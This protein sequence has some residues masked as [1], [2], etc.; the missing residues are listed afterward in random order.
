MQRICQCHR[1]ENMLFLFL[2]TDARLRQNQQEGV[3]QVWQTNQRG[4]VSSCSPT[5]AAEKK[6]DLFGLWLDFQEDWDKVQC[7]VERRS[8]STNLS[9]SEWCAVQAKEL[10]GKMESGKFDELIKK[11]VEAGLYYKDLDFPDD[12]EERGFSKPVFTHVC[13]SSF[14]FVQS[15]SQAFTI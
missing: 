7:E 8:E 14:H 15:Y 13:S 1:Y 11:R 12:P 6:T 3:G 10:R 9:R 2:T 4:A 5:H